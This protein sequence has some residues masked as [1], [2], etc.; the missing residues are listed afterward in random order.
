[1]FNIA[2]NK[3]DATNQQSGLMTFTSGFTPRQLSE[4]TTLTISDIVVTKNTFKTFIITFGPEF[5]I[6][7]ATLA[8]GSS[9]YSKT[10]DPDSK[11]ITLEKLVTAVNSFSISGIIGPAFTP[12]TNINFKT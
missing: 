2:S 1:M 3:F 10:I 11:T 5:D 6:A 9:S 4:G 7:A 12:S 8:S